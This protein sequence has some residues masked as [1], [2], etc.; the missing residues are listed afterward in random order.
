MDK[1]GR[2]YLAALLLFILV[3][4]LLCHIPG[5]ALGYEPPVGIFL[6]SKIRPYLQAL[7]GLEDEIDFDYQVFDL[8]ENFELA[9][10]YAKSRRFQTCVAIGP[11]AIK[12]LYK[13]GSAIPNKLAIMALDLEKL[14]GN[15]KICGIDLRIPIDF[16]LKVIR[17]KFGPGKKVAVLYN[18]AENGAIIEKAKEAAKSQGLI[19]VPLEVNSPSQIMEKLTPTFST[20]D[21][22]LFIPDSVVISEKVVSH[23]TKTALLNGVAV[24]GFNRFFYETGA[25]L[26]FIIDYEEIGREAA[27]LLEKLIREHLCIF[28]PP[29]VKLLWNRRALKILMRT[30]PDKW[31][32]LNFVGTEE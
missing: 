22:I 12:L 19:L 28:E 15:H 26:S 23:I 25:L 14:I 2:H 32:E 7:H 11:E 6:S 10:H 13:Y 1:R 27:R 4:G 24:C 9:K 30:R 31:K 29:K 18:Q 3:P 5:P 16:Q 21:I 20:V 17:E 8:S